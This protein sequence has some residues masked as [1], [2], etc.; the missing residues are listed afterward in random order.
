MKKRFPKLLVFIGLLSLSGNAVSC[1]DPVDIKK[2]V[3][4]DMT[5][6]RNGENLQVKQIVTNCKTN[7]G[8]EFTIM[9]V[10]D[11][12]GASC[13]WVSSDP[14]VAKVEGI[15]ITAV[16]IGETLITD[17]NGSNAMIKITV[18]E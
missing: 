15:K 5:T 6:V 9:L 8:S 11:M 1:S 4:L 13:K 16:G 3:E 7:V 10:G 17:A 14:N 18:E 2:Y 12:E